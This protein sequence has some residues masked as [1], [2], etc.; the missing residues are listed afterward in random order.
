MEGGD[1]GLE[2]L[3]GLGDVFVGV[4][5]G[6]IEF[7][8]ALEDSVFLNEVSEAGLDGV[9]GGEGRAVVGEGIAGEYDVEDGVFA[10][11]LGG[12]FG[13]G[14][15]GVEGLAEFVVRRFPDAFVGAFLAE[16]GEG[17]EAGGAGD[18]VAVEGADLSDVV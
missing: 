1:D 8:G 7:L 3:D 9:V 11:G 4:G 18:G 10:G 17:G 5:Q 6:G 12:N 2:G 14:A 16:F 13:L 15:G